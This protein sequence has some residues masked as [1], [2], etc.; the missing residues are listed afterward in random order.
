VVSVTGPYGRI[1]AGLYDHLRSLNGLGISPD[2][3]IT[4]L[5]FQDELWS[6]ELKS[7]LY[8]ESVKNVVSCLDQLYSIFLLAYTQM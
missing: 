3:I 7:S 2:Q 6:M 4:S 1:L 5:D 8:C